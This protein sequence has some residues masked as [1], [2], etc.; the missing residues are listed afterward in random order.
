MTPPKPISIRFSAEEREYLEAF[1]REQGRSLSNAVRAIVRGHMIRYQE[2]VR[3]GALERARE[4]ASRGWEL[5]GQ[6]S[7]E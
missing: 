4:I 7:D 3:A 5:S 6:G 2:Q 1:A